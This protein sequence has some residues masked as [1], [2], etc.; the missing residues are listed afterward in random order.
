M[1]VEA[2]RVTSIGDFRAA[3][4]L[5]ICLLLIP[6]QGSCAPDCWAHSEV[7]WQTTPREMHVHRTKAIAVTEQF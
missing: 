5:H 7:H 6:V 4:E 2:A 1:Q 3:V